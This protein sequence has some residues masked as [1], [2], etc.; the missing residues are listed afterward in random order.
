MGLFLLILACVAPPPVTVE[1]DTSGV[2]VP[3]ATAPVWP[4]LGT[5]FN[6]PV[7]EVPRDMGRPGVFV[8][9]GH[10]TGRNHGNV[11][12]R[13]QVEEHF[14]LDATDDL[15]ARLDATGVF[16]VT[17]AR[18]ASYRP[19]YASRIAHLHRSDAAV[20]LELHSDARAD[21]LYPHTRR[22]DGSWCYAAD[23]DPGIA[24]LV[25]DQGPAAEVMPRL[26]LARRVA[27][28]LVD[29]GFSAYD[30]NNYGEQYD[31]DTT[32]GVFLDRRGLYML[33]RARVPAILIETHN[34]YDAREAER[35]DEEATRDA[36]GRAVI[37]A[38]VRYFGDEDEPG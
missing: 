29:A 33:K 10:G 16:E 9:A 28:A 7:I 34:A 20:M 37:E 3:E 19:S 22:E 32:P 31:L 35:W 17:R 2:A 13:C 1:G 12:C 30:G 6:H 15:A 8:V 11:G 5:V 36:F 4:Q 14:T 27:E 23:D 25:R 21:A 18:S 38:L 26:R 24:I